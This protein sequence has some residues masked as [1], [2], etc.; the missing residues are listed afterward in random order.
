MPFNN[1]TFSA[2]DNQNF[3]RNKGDIVQQYRS[4][5]CPCGNDPG[6]SITTCAVCGG[7][8][9]FYPDAPIIKRAIIS[10]VEQSE[11]QLITTGFAG[12][13]DLTM[14]EMPGDQN[15]AEEFDIIMLPKWAGMPFSG[16][17]V[18]RGTDT[19]VLFYR[20]VNIDKCVSVDPSTGAVTTYT[21]NA[22]FSWSGRTITWLTANQP[23]Q[24]SNYSIRYTALFEYVVFTPALVRREVG[25][26]IGSK[27]ILRKRHII[28]PNM[29]DLII[30]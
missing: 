7:M 23:A 17:I 13:G 19:D 24:G 1:S 20:A 8:G 2:M 5:V 3:F 4:M 18:T 15:P 26:D 25:T 16:Q 21:H 27:A 28:M 6:E 22:D 12:P 30:S 10:R 14:S 29:P 9:R 11:P